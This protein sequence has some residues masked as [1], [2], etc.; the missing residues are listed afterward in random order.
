MKRT[1]FRAILCICVSA[2]F[3]PNAFPQTGTS[4]L[5]GSMKIEG[6]SLQTSDRVSETG[7]TLSTPD[8]RIINWHAAVVPGT[9]VASLAN[10]NIIPDPNYGI[11]LRNLIGEKFD[12]NKE[13]N[14]LAM[15]P[16]SPFAI[17]W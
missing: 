1:V 17:P 15:D 13:Q 10:D 8:S 4:A 2:A 16:E 7:E 6:W 3:V 14:D 9:I 11:N 5:E 12:S